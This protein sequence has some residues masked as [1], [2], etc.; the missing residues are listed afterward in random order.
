MRRR[1]TPSSGKSRRASDRPRLA[2]IVLAAGEGTRMRSRRAKVLHEAAGRPLIEHVVR[3]ARAAGADPICVVVGVQGGE[4]R[5]RLGAGYLYAEQPRRRG[6]ADAVRR[7]V[8]LLRGFRGD[9]LLLCGDVPA[10]PASALRRLVRRHRSRGAALT[11]LSAVLDDPTGYGRIVRDEAG[12]MTAIVEQR[13]AGARERAIHEVNS[14]TYCARWKALRE[15]LGRI[16]PDNAQGE[17]YLTDAVRLLLE[18]GL[19]VEAVIHEPAWEAFGVNSRRQLADMHRLLNRR[20]L[21]RLMARGVT[22]LDPATTWVHDTVRVG[23]DTVLHPG[24][25]LE[26]ATRIGTDCTIRSGS[27]LTDVVVGNGCTILEHTVAEES[28]IGAGSSVGPFARLRPGSVIGRG[29][30]IG[31]FVETKKTRLGE[32]SKASHLSYLG[33]ATIGRGVNIGAGTITCNY[34]GEHKH[35]TRLG[36][37]V[38]V[39]SDTQFVA[40][41]TVGA[42]AYVAAGSVITEDVPPQALAIARSRQRNVAGWAARRR[43]RS[44]RR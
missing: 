16:R 15:A 41:V 34:D 24:V 14:G 9:V 2:A 18:R 5:T 17:Y 35:P 22:V 27:R 8:P 29:C 25:V 36:D 37:G 12:C 26:G 32:A 10:L 4:I 30:K 28:R 21:E 20:H 13:D 44:E 33:D 39:G 43:K 40:P 42:G 3:A 11:V 7:A 19:P 38:F 31:N 23:R 1:S 6:T